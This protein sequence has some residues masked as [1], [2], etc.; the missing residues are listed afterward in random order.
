MWISLI[1]RIN[2]KSHFIHLP[3]WWIVAMQVSQEI[4][5]G[6]FLVGSGFHYQW[7]L[8]LLNRKENS[9]YHHQ[10]KTVVA[11]LDSSI[12]RVFYLSLLMAKNLETLRM[13]PLWPLSCDI[14]S[15]KMIWGTVYFEAIH[16]VFSRYFHLSMYSFVSLCLE[17]NTPYLMQAGFHREILKTQVTQWNTRL[18]GE[19]KSQP[20]MIVN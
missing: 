11:E 9:W 3:C 18:P 8:T 16:C 15:H 17:V 6:L 4:S 14:G 19:L 20:E 1:T 5:S 12:A 13:A 7:L 2:L 10:L